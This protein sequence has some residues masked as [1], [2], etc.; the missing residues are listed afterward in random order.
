MNEVCTGLETANRSGGNMQHPSIFGYLTRQLEERPDADAYLHRGGKMTF[1]ELHETTSKLAGALK[2][3]GVRPSDRV[4]MVMQD[5]IELVL[6]ILAAMGMGAIAVPINPLLSEADICHVINDSGAKT[7]FVSD[8]YLETALN[9]EPQ[10]KNLQTIVTTEPGRPG[11]GNF[12]EFLHSGDAETLLNRDGPA[13]IL[14]TS[15]STG[16]PKGALH[17]NSDICCI[18]ESIGRKVY[19]IQPSDRMFSASRT[20]FAYGFGNTIGFTIGFGAP[21]ILLSDRPTPESIAKIFDEFDP[22]IFFAVPTIFRNI[23]EY[24]RQGGVFRTSSLKFSAAGGENLPPRTF[25]EWKAFT[26]TPILETIGS[27]ELLHGYITN[28]KQSI[29]L[30]S[31]GLAVPGYEIKLIDDGGREGA[32]G[33]LFVKGGSAFH[34]YWNDERKTSETII[35]GYV[36]SGDIFRRDDEGFYFFEGRSDDMFKS[37]GMWVSPI[38]V[39]DVLRSHDDVSDAAVVGIPAHDGTFEVVAFVALRKA[40]K[41]Q[42][43]VMREL[44]ELSSSV[45]PRYKRPKKIRVISELPRNPTGKV[46]RY[47]LRTE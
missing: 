9:L 10:L 31:T 11:I 36:R 26:G 40:V 47:K 30:G 29:K 18:V 13:F 35:D 33:V 1:R 25:T 12:A 19:E 6:A 21:M 42:D 46:Q 14:Y 28:Q 3:R 5:S 20:P 37:S 45:L 15:G 34:H 27:T 2:A 24:R 23:L 41:S 44:H 38:D 22:T 8:A 7:L 43:E 16:R 17:H 4:A 32:Q 39:E